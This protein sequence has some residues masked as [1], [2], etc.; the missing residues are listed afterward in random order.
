M[1]KIEDEKKKLFIQRSYIFEF[2]LGSLFYGHFKNV[3]V[4][5]KI[6]VSF[7]NIAVDMLSVGAF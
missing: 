7:W 6:F 2:T 4:Q 5:W 3:Y 1:K